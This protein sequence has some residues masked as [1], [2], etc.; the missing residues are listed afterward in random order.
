MSPNAPRRFKNILRSW[1]LLVPGVAAL[2]LYLLVS[3]EP[4]Y[5]APFLVLVFLGLFPGILLENPK[6]AAKRTVISTMV[7]ATSLMVLTALFV[8]YHLAGFPRGDPGEVLECLSRWAN[9]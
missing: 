8:V 9:L 3:V 1:P 6:D 5:V 4:R 2:C 7:I